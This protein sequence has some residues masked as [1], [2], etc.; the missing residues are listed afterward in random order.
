MEVSWGRW[1]NHRTKWLIFHCPPHLI[2]GGSIF[3]K[4]FLQN[5]KGSP[6]GPVLSLWPPGVGNI[7]AELQQSGSFLSAAW[8]SDGSSPM[9]PSKRLEGSNDPPYPLFFHVFWRYLPLHKLTL[10]MNTDEYRTSGTSGTKTAS[11]TVERGRS[12]SIVA[13]LDFPLVAPA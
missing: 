6:S 5:D 1:K 2:T 8:T 3:P 13:S 7:Q 9:I 10:S 11:S 4:Q 12:M